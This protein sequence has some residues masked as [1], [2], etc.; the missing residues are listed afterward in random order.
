MCLEGAEKRHRAQQGRSRCRH[1]R[2][3]WRALWACEVHVA[4]RGGVHARADLELGLCKPLTC[5]APHQGGA[6]TDQ[7]AQDMASEPAIVAFAGLRGW[8]VG[9]L[10]HWVLQC[11]AAV[12]L[13]LAHGVLVDSIGSLGFGAGTRVMQAILSWARALRRHYVILQ[14]LPKS[15]SFDEKL[16]S[17]PLKDTG[18]TSAKVKAKAM[19]LWECTKPMPPSLQRSGQ[20]WRRRL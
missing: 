13:S 16:C 19:Q 7:E 3:T 12:T 18:R 1:F 14:A 6:R 8:V 17:F 11:G 10:G 4:L 2:C 15:V 20:L 5:F 9:W